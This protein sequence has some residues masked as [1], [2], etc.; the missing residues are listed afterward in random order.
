M[1]KE[2]KNWA[3][4]D[5][6][7]KKFYTDRGLPVP[8]GRKWID[9]QEEAIKAPE[10]AWVLEESSVSEEALDPQQPPGSSTAQG[11]DV[12]TYH[13]STIEERV[14]DYERNSVDPNAECMATLLRNLFLKW[15]V[16][17]ILVKSFPYC[18]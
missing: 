14:S 10:E 15:W 8:A 6:N 16:G 4:T 11:D 5:A 7:K 2:P 1:C 18:L 17:L 12:L 13:R 3:R 9:D